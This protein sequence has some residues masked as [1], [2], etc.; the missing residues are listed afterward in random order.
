MDRFLEEYE[1]PKVIHEETE[2]LNKP[3]TSEDIELVS[4]I[5]ISARKARMASLMNSTEHFEKN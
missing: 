1:L 3:M 2:N 5:S 4:K